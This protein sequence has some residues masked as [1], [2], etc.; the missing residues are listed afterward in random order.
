MSVRYSFTY[1]NIAGSID[2]GEISDCAFRS[3]DS[4][5]T[6]IAADILNS[7][8]GNGAVDWKRYESDVFASEG[9]AAC[10]ENHGLTIS[11][12]LKKVCKSVESR[13]LAQEK[14]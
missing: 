3:V 7:Y 1:G 11:E 8:T 10:F 2:G 4:G 14:K 6:S 5:K 13:L 12:N 9:L